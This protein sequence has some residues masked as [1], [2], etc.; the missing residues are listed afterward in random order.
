MVADG[1]WG[2]SLGAFVDLLRR[3]GYSLVNLES[4]EVNAFFIR[5]QDC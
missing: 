1:F 2:A 5:E 4:N 3:H